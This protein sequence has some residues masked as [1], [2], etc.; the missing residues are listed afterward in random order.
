MHVQKELLGVLLNHIRS[1]GLIS[2]YTCSRAMDLVYSGRF[3]QYP[4]C[5]TEEA[6]GHERAP[7]TP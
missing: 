6:G 2:D 5:L 7:D 3:F 1:L 4:V